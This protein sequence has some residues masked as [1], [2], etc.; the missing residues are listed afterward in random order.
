MK[1]KEQL[2]LRTILLFVVAFGLVFTACKDDKEDTPKPDLSEAADI[3]SFVFGG[4]T[5]PVDGTIT[6]TNIAVSVPFDV[7]VTALVP[8]VVISADASV[9]PATGVAQDFSSPVTYTVTAED[10]TTTKEYVVTVT[11]LPE[12]GIVIT[13]VW[14]RNLAGS[15]RPDWFTP[16]NDRDLAVSAD[17]V[18]V[19]NNN[20]KIRVLS[21][22]DGSDVEAQDTTFINGKENFASGNLFLLNVATDDNGVILGSNLRNGNGVNAWNLYKWN[23]K[24]ATQELFFGGYVPLAGEA[25]ADNLSVVG[26]VDG[27]G[28]IYVPADGFG[29]ASNAVLKFT[30]TGGVVNATPL[31]IELADQTQ[32][33]NG[34]DAYPT[35]S[36]TD[37]TII[38]AGTSI[39]GLAEY[40]Q[41]GALVARLDSAVLNADPM[42]APLVTFA[43]DVKP[44]EISGRKMIATT[45]TDFTDNAADDGYLYIIDYTDGLGNV[46]ADDIMRVAFTPDGNIEKNNNGTGGVD[47]LVDGNTATVYAMI[48]NF[49]VGAYTITYE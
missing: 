32:I 20:D 34:N 35:S 46:T 5:P 19:H 49:G 33:G 41:T 26:S 24:D 30:I 42:T 6:G 2:K 8:T 43:L 40:D 31:K 14:E 1:L 3:T 16:N 10:G 15:G 36:A 39:R 44:F 48:T 17:Y 4:L 28:F 7:D 21:L 9:V 22:A 29:G 25:L 38:V 12:P 23:D 47:V 18:Y 37:A 27:D 45:A 13:P 11:I